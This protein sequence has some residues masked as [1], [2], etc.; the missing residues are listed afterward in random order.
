MHKSEHDDFIFVV[1]LRTGD[2]I[3]CQKYAYSKNDKRTRR[4]TELRRHVH[5]I[6]RFLLIFTNSHMCW[7]HED[8]SSQDKTAKQIIKKKKEKRT[9]S[10]TQVI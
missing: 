3:S 6:G 10:S 1:M 9:T 5:M 7:P 8:I 4:E 2:K